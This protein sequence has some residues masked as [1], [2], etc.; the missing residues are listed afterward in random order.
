MKHDYLI[1][2]F[3]IVFSL[4][5]IIILS[6]LFIIISIILLLTGEHQVI[7]LQ[8]RIG[9][10]CD[11]FYVY[12]FTTMLKNSENMKGGLL[13]RKNDPRILPVG[14]ILRNT[15]LN[16]LP[17]LFNILFG[18]MSIVGPRPQSPVHFNLYNEE[19]K[20]YISKLKPGFTGIGSLIFRYE[21]N[22]LEKMKYDYD[23]SHDKII[24]PYKGELEKWFYKNRSLYLYFKIIFLT[25]FVNFLPNIKVTRFF[26]NLPK[27]PD[28]LE[29]LI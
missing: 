21:D 24:T 29:G 9:Y 16:E 8:K 23:Y 12:K 26:S 6:P 1:R 5:A 15:N 25:A 7:Y 18:S 10:R 17:Q 27:M 3:D 28:E 11:Q 2:F 22:I 19:Q 13:T 14:K 20:A 4:I